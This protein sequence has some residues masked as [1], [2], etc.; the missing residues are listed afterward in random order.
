MALKSKKLAAK[1][2]PAKKAPAK[3]AAARSASTRFP[4]AKSAGPVRMAMSVPKSNYCPDHGR[5]LRADRTCPV[6]DCQYHD[7][8]VPS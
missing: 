6:K 4:V 3:K 2:P 5:L 8:P 7:M 1:K